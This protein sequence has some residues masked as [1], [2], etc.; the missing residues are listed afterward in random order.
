MVLN[1]GPKTT[2][3]FYIPKTHR[4]LQPLGAAPARQ[5]EDSAAELNVMKAWVQS[6]EQRVDPLY[7]Q[8]NG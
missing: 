7:V 5:F 3:G 6:F 2:S 1:S 4:A 8:S